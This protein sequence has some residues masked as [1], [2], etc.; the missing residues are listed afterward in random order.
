LSSFVSGELILGIPARI[1]ISRPFFE[2]PGDISES[3][4]LLDFRKGLI[5]FSK[6]GRCPETLSVDY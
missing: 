4:L 6:L 2:F 3:L 1:V 5:G